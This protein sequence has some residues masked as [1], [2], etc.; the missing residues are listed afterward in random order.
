MRDLIAGEVLNILRSDE[1]D[2]RVAGYGDVA[3]RLLCRKETSWIRRWKWNGVR[4]VEE[5]GRARVWESERVERLAPRLLGWIP[6]SRYLMK[7]T[8]PGDS[9]SPAGLWDKREVAGVRYFPEIRPTYL[10]TLIRKTTLSQGCKSHWFETDCQDN[11]KICHS[12]EKEHLRSFRESSIL[13][14]NEKV[15]I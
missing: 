6:V 14:R 4:W 12:I 2:A 7:R 10:V 11:R 13:Y 9:Y 15:L 5:F 8:P 1:T 3:E